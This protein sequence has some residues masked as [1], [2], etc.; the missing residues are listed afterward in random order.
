MYHRKEMMLVDCYS[1]RDHHSKMRKSPA[2]N[3]NLSFENGV[4]MLLTVD[5]GKRDGC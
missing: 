2:S 5:Y 4:P 3:A 1:R